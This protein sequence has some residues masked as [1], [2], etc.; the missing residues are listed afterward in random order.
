MVLYFYGLIND[1]TNVSG[2]ANSSTT[3]K[4]R[5]NKLISGFDG[6][7]RHLYYNS[8]SGGNLKHFATGSSGWNAITWDTTWPKTTSTYQ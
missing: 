8:G 3:F 6:Y 5:K 1:L 7:E 2:S 4:R